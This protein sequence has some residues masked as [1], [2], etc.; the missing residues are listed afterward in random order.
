MGLRKK[1][2]ELVYGEEIVDFDK[3]GRDTRIEIENDFREKKEKEKKEELEMEQQKTQRELGA[4]REKE[5]VDKERNTEIKYEI[6]FYEERRSE[7]CYIPADDETIEADIFTDEGRKSLL[8]KSIY[9]KGFNKNL[10]KFGK[11]KKTTVEDVKV[12][13]FIVSSKE[14]NF[15]SEKNDIAYCHP[16]ACIAF[17]H[18]IDSMG[19]PHRFK[20]QPNFY[21]SKAHFNKAI[22]SFV[23]EKLKSRAT[24]IIIQEIDKIIEEYKNKNIAKEVESLLENGIE[25]SAHINKTIGGENWKEIVCNGKG[26]DK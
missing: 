11:A 14:L 20:L 16:E 9:V 21:A 6:T 3:Y 15:I 7:E 1:I 12:F 2:A 26:D 25:T 19:V 24:E 13:G 4:Q 23:D 18:E 17:K 22:K 10:T 8:G 5:R